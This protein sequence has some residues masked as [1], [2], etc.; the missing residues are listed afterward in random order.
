MDGN[1]NSPTPRV[2]LW[3]GRQDRIG[4]I[5]ADMLTVTGEKN[6][7]AENPDDSSTELLSFR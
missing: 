2:R 1:S 4:R 6:F 7:V 5:R 3:V